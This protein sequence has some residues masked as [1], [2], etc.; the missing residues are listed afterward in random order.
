MTSLAVA[1]APGTPVPASYP[2]VIW[3]LLGGNFLIS[4][5]AFAYPFMAYLVA[6]R[7]HAATTVGAVLAAFGIGWVFGQLVCGWLIDRLGRRLTLTG[8]M[9]F[10]AVALIGMASAHSVW[11]LLCGAALVGLVYDAPRPVVGAAISELIPDPQRRAKVDGWRFGWVINGGAAVSGGLGGLLAGELG[12]PVLFWIDGMVCAV[13]SALVLCCLPRDVSRPAE[14]K[15]Y[16]QAFRDRRL[17]LLLASGVAT[18]TAVLGLYAAMPMLM[19]RHGL[20]AGAYGLAFMANAL[21]VMT[22]APLLT[23]WLSRRVAAD[24][25]LGIMAAAAVWTTACMSIGALSTTTMGFSL[26]AAACAP[27]EIA[28][29][30]VAIGIVHRIAP[31]ARRGIYHGVWGTALAIAAVCSPILASVSLELGGAPLVAATTLAAGLAGAA[32]SLK[33]TPIIAKPTDVPTEA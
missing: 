3:L 30:I 19:I 31:P 8:T 20:D 4:T 15:G 5:A 23:P 27:G 32:L 33:L 21:T 12:I 2:A 13:F 14:H 7:G 28:W 6:E 18:L 26:A 11:I 1:D 9:L 24:P 17:V 22:I 16:R 25:R 29:F 10:A